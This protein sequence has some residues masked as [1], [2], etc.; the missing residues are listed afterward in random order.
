MEINSL[1]S[2]KQIS[3][4]TVIMTLTTVIFV[5][6]LGYGVVFGFNNPTATPPNEAGQVLSVDTSGNVGIGGT[7]TSDK[8]YVSG[9]ILAD[10][11]V[12][13]GTTCL[14]AVGGGGGSYW[15]DTSGNIYNT[16]VGNVGIGVGAGGP[17]DAKL[18]ISGGVTIDGVLQ[19]GTWQSR[20]PLDNVI[21]AVDNTGDVGTSPSMT[22][23]L[24]GLPIIAYMDTD[25]N[26][27]KVLKCGNTSCT[28]TSGNIITNLVTDVLWS[29]TAPSLS[30]TLTND[31]KPVI[32]YFDEGDLYAAKCNDTA[33][34][35]SF[36]GSPYPL[37]T[38]GD[39][40]WEPSSIARS[41]SSAYNSSPIISYYDN[42]NKKLKL[43]RCNNINCNSGS[44]ELIT[45]GGSAD[46][47]KYSS[48]GIDVNGY[49]MVSFQD[50]SNKN[51]K[52]LVCS[53][54][55]VG[56]CDI[57]TF[58]T[59]DTGIEAGYYTAITIG[60][61]GFPII[62]YI[63]NTF[64]LRVVK[65]TSLNCLSFNA[66]VIVDD[67]ASLGSVSMTLAEDGFPIIAYR[68]AGILGLK[69]AKCWS[70]T[71][72]LT[73][74]ISKATIDNVGGNNGVSILINVGGLPMVAYHDNNAG[75][76]DLKVARCG[77]IACFPYWTRR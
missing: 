24:D 15:G 72:S 66:P 53:G 1:T 71:C 8:L 21:V 45:D 39:V 19:Q 17:F 12:C 65:C 31:G 33:C 40:G 25:N 34:I 7:P 77:N 6:F 58:R 22:I 28:S 57:K 36:T 61:D 5:V 10:D 56:G 50:V 18:S 26:A 52:L 47:G 69:F 62:A 44:A 54:A 55:T 14:N 70:H 64:E 29:G 23:G 11:D 73:S 35:S 59:L 63:A 49:P 41:G 32:I 9:S 76:N 37:D 60:A 43:Y 20:L 27:L 67:G 46:Y 2:A 68:Q 13:T 42:T 75:E 74:G 3:W 30:I 38:P 4:P 16:N 48:I 51:L